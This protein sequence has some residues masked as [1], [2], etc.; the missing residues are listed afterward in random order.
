MYCMLKVTEVDI[1]L[2]PFWN[3][4]LGIALRD[5]TDENGSFVAMYLS[6]GL[7]LWEV[8]IWFENM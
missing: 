4:Y 1:V 8:Q 5:F 3:F 7:F 6:F 2:L